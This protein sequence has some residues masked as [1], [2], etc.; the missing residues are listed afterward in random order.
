MAERP[1]GTVTFLFADLEGSTRLWEEYPEPMKAALSRH[2]DILRAAVEANGGHVVKSTGDGC[3]AAFTTAADA[4]VAAVEAQRG[5]NAETWEVTGPLRVRM[6]VHTGEAETRDGDY[7]GP[8]LNRAA[9]LTAAAHGGQIVVSHATEGIVRDTLGRGI[10]LKDLGEHQLRDLSRSERIFQV[11]HAALPDE[12]PVL[13]SLDSAP[14]NLPVQV[15]SFVGRERDLERIAGELR[16]TAVVTLTGVGGVGKT[17]L[18]L[19]LAAEV[20]PSYRDG[21]WLC[22]LAAVRDPDA[23][24]DAVLAIFGLQPREG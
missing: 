20:V 19:Q 16:D 11:A 2:D 4:L 10:E 23:V 21:A 9:R 8:T 17:R 7:Y 5:L 18:A 3:L 14:G 15:T 1:T 12:F 24:P 13:R 6:G 22:E